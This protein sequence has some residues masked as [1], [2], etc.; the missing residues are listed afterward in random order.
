MSFCQ[1]SSLYGI[2]I[3]MEEC[4]KQAV[5]ENER[6][7]QEALSLWVAA[8]NKKDWD[9][10]FFCVYKACLYMAKNKCYNIVVRDLDDKV[11]D[12]TLD[13]MNKIREGVRPDKLSSFCYLY[14][15][16]K[17]WSKKEI[18]WD[19][20][21]DVDY[22]LNVSKYSYDFDEDDKLIT[23]ILDIENNDNDYIGEDE[24]DE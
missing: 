9:R 24:I 20:A 18:R 10:M 15:I 19:R 8:N 5:E 4:N 2:E 17:L 14:T 21:D 1:K 3:R 22:Y 23:N 16:G 12:A 11:M 7:F 6:N 13:V